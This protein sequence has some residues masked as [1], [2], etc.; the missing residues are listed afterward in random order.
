VNKLY[1]GRTVSKLTHQ[2]NKFTHYKK[3]EN[4]ILMK[5]LNMQEACF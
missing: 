4:V 5:R 2:G 1:K 3:E